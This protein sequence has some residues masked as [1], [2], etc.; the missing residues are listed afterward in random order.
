MEGAR[1]VEAGA[2]RI[3]ELEPAWRALYDHHRE[4]ARGIS[5]M[6]PFE[7]TW[8]RRRE[9]YRRWLA[10]GDGQLLVAERGGRIVGYAMVTSGDGPATWDFGRG[11]VEIETLAVLAEERGGG[12][13]AALMRA[14][15]G[16]ARGRE[17]DVIA[18]GLYHT[19]DGARRFYERE[20]FRPFYLDMARDLR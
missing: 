20:G 9:Q 16:W 18:V 3:G 10:D 15:E 1:V 14:S 6:R 2:D 13:G 8:R 4:I 17:A 19:N 12:V 7:E 11:V 5:P